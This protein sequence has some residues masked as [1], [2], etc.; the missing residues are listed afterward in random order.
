MVLS[1]MEIRA[2]INAK[3][4]VFDPPIPDDPAQNQTGRIGS[5]SVDLLLHDELIVLPEQVSG[6]IIDPSVARVDVM[7]LLRNNGETRSLSDGP[8]QMEQNRLVIGKTLE[9]IQLPAHIAARIEG[10]STLARLGLAVHVTAPTVLAGFRGRLYLE[11][12]NLGPFAV[13]LRPGMRIGQ[14]VL[15]RTGLPP[16]ANY[17]GQYQSQE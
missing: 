9:T 10:R 8:F 14:L 2:E 17:G 16:T 15:E 7:A 13:Q 12:Y 6:I 11:M 4:L 5:S 3:R 1:N